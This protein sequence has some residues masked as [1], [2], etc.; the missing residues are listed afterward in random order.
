VLGRVYYP[1]NI[2]KKY[3]SEAKPSNKLYMMSM[4]GPFILENA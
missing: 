1:I 3:A 2:F 4:N